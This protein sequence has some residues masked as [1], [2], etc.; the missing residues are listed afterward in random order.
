MNIKH[1]CK[2][3]HIYFY[4]GRKNVELKIIK[5]PF[6]GSDS[7]LR[8]ITKFLLVQDDETLDSFYTNL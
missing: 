6:Y 4:Y 2:T 8:I 5:H 1:Q 7:A 3:S